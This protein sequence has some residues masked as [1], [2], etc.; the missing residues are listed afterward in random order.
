MTGEFRLC[1]G[2]LRLSVAR[3]SRDGL[4]GAAADPVTECSFLTCQ[5]LTAEIVKTIRDII[6]LN[7]LYRSV[8]CG[9]P[10]LGQGGLSVVPGWQRFFPRVSW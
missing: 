5:A 7:P 1:F 6:A 3:T 9:Q 8:S 4:P 10:F 2:S